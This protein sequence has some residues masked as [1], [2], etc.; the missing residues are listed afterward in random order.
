MYHLSA[1]PGL[2]EKGTPAVQHERSLTGALMVYR[3]YDTGVPV[4]FKDLSIALLCTDV[5]K[6][7]LLDLSGRTCYYVPNRH[8]DDVHGKV[9]GYRCLLVVDSAQNVDPGL[10]WWMTTVSITDNS[11]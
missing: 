10:D 11:L 1:S 7:K 9:D 6:E 4:R 2:N 8:S 5:E 3:L